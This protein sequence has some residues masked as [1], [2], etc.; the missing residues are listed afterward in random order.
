METIFSPDGKIATLLGIVIVTYNS[1][2][3]LTPVLESCRF[4]TDA[5][6]VVIDNASEDNSVQIARAAGAI[7]CANPVNRGFAAAVNQGVQ[8][9]EGDLVL[10]LNPDTELLT[11]IDALM[12]ACCEPQVAAAA[13]TL[14]DIRTHRPQKGILNPAFAVGGNSPV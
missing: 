6:I 2:G 4:R 11:P 3:V 8:Q 14:L 9:L 1:A 7:V 5:S 10:L 13:G 12:N